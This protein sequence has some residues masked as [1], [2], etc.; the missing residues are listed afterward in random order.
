MIAEEQASLKLSED[1]LKQPYSN[2]SLNNVKNQE[3]E[4]TVVTSEEA[5]PVNKPA[6]EKA[7]SLEETT[8][9]TALSEPAPF[10]EAVPEEP[11]ENKESTSAKSLFTFPQE[12]E[13]SACLC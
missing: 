7:A 6:L 4:T 3:V 10:E 12:T 13:K 2:L 1:K 8:K 11:K 9:E 5:F